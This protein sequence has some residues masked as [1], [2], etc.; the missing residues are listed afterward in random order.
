MNWMDAF[1]IDFD[2]SLVALC[3]MAALVIGTVYSW[4]T[5]K[6]GFDL[7]QTCT[8]SATGKISVEKIA[9][10]TFLAIW[11]WGFVALIL[12]DRLTEWYVLIG[13]TFVLGRAWSQKL[14]VDSKPPESKPLPPA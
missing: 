5:K 13:S 6:E 9:Y 7:S 2:A 8:D 11:T 4:H 10:M 12:R 14:S 1:L 3:I